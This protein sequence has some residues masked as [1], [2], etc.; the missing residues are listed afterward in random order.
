MNEEILSNEEQSHLGA[1]VKNALEGV[2]Y[3]DYLHAR[4][5]R[6]RM[7]G[8]TTVVAAMALAI[9]V[10]TASSPT[11]STPAWSA[12]PQVMSGAEQDDAVDACLAAFAE[13]S[14]SSA[15][16]FTLL[17]YRGAVGIFTFTADG[18]S[19]ICGVATTSKKASVY[20]EKPGVV[21]VDENTMVKTYAPDGLAADF[22]LNISKMELATDITNYPTATVI[23]GSTPAGVQ[24]VLVT[25]DGLPEAQANVVNNSFA[26]WVPSS[27]QAVIDFV[28]SNGEKV[29]ALTVK[30]AN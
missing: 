6:R 16:E 9:S 13:K 25:I 10:G 30:S 27:G 19:W 4:A 15:S 3:R 20:Q 24:K 1:R 29:S 17:D 7:I 22:R 18:N 26:I 28:D 14:T 12:E 21:A 8:A 23:S 5:K 11:I 2:S